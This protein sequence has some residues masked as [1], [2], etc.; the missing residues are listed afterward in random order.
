M[1]EQ[2]GID[3]GDPQPLER[4]VGADEV[5]DHVGGRA[6]EDVRGR[7]VLLEDSADVQDGDPVAHL[8]RLLDVVGDEHHRLA[9]LLVEPQELVL[10]PRARHRVDR[11]ERLVHEDA[12]AGR[13]QAPCATPTRWRWPPDSCAG[14]RPR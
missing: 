14:Y 2:S 8:D 6:P 10:E 5:G 3:L 9:H 11:A 7:V 13:R 4:A 12:P 1:L